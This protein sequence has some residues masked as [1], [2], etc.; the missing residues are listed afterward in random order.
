MPVCKRSGCQ[1]KLN[2]VRSNSLY[3]C[4]A[5][6][7]GK[8]HGPACQM[9]MMA[10][11]SPRTD[12]IIKSVSI[13]SWG[14]SKYGNYI[15]FKFKSEGISNAIG[16]NYV[17]HDAPNTANGILLQG[18]VRYSAEKSQIIFTNLNLIDN[19]ISLEISL[20]LP[21]GVV[22]NTIMSPLT[23]L[24]TKAYKN[25]NY[26]T[27]RPFLNQEVDTVL[28]D[29]NRNNR[30]LTWNATFTP[31]KFN[32]DIYFLVARVSNSSCLN[33]SYFNTPGNIVY[34]ER[35]S[36]VSTIVDFGFNYAVMAAYGNQ[37]LFSNVVQA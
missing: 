32:G 34:S 30:A 21:G 8:G 3:C 16:I 25:C 11:L 20:K 26:F 18:V 12:P 10:R 29:F 14:T 35:G 36:G 1:H 33:F 9:K 31:D 17:I 15:V 2:S 4:R 23:D 22:T 7:L 6:M 27:R 28:I 24:S 13:Y 19:K 5:C 37:Y